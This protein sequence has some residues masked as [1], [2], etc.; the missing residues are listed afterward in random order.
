MQGPLGGGAGPEGLN[1]GCISK[2]TPAGLQMDWMC[3]MCVKEKSKKKRHCGQCGCQCFT[4][5][6]GRGSSSCTGCKKGGWKMNRICNPCDNRQPFIILSGTKEE[7]SN[8]GR[9]Y[10]EYVNSSYR[11]IVKHCKVGRHALKI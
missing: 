5:N 1:S 6:W 11:Y 3:E 8:G 2:V 9:L 7:T 4:L 10:S